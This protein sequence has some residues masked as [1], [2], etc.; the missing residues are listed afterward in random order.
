MRSDSLLH[1]SKSYL[2]FTVNNIERLSW[3]KLFKNSCALFLRNIFYVII[4][5]SIA[6]EK[7]VYCTKCKDFLFNFENKIHLKN[8]TFAPNTKTR[9]YVVA[10]YFFGN[11]ILPVVIHSVLS[12]SV[13]PDHYSKMCTK[14]NS[15]Y[16][17]KC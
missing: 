14:N 2:K 10:V 9:L 4:M 3:N 16:R 12:R 5:G 15:E 1:V 8:E 13:D 6:I 11:K 17:Q 7:R